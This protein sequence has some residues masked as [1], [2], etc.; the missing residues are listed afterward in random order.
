MSQLALLRECH[1]DAVLH[2]FAQLRDKHNAWLALD[3][4]YP[5]I[6]NDFIGC[7]WKNYYGNVEEVLPPDAPPPRG[8]DVDLRMYVDSDHAGEKKT[9]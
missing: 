7:D 2:C 5:E 8:K 1:M 9:R 4:P 3:P 6:G